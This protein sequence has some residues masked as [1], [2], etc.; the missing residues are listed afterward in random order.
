MHLASAPGKQLDLALQ[1]MEGS[2]GNLPLQLGLRPEQGKIGPDWPYRRIPASAD[3][4]GKR[5][6]SICTLIS[7]YRSSDGGRQDQTGADVSRH[8]ENVT[9]FTIRQLS[10][11]SLRR[12]SF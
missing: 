11:P 10:T 7:F 8:H 6:R 9:T 5:R 1:A 2:I 12:T 3:Y 4:F